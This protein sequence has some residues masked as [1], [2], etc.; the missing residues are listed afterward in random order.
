VRDDYVGWHR[1]DAHL[2]G[3]RQCAAHIIRHCEGVLELHTDWQ[4]WAEQVITVPRDAAKA[5]AAGA[6]AADA[7][8]LD[9][10]LL[11]EPRQRY[12]KAVEWGITTN[13]P[14]D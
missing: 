9:P 3:V 6:R 12:D 7:D 14:R 5:V 2:A 13:P 11:A 10:Q 8:H 4:K 1:F